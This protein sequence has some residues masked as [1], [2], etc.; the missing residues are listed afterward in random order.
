MKEKTGIDDQNSFAG[1]VS[2]YLIGGLVRPPYMPEEYGWF[3]AYNL[4]FGATKLL[5]PG[6]ESF[7]Y[8]YVASF[9]QTIAP[10]YL[11]CLG[12]EL[13]GDWSHTGSRSESSLESVINQEHMWNEDDSDA[14]V[15]KNINPVLPDVSEPPSTP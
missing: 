14:P 7:G 5:C 6:F 8:T 2:I 13:Y 10:L 11:N 12:G 9:F 4:G 15:E 1:V 3:N